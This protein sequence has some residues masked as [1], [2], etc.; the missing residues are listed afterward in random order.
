METSPINIAFIMNGAK[1]PRGGEFLTL[2]LITHLRKDIFHPILIY[3]ED[4][5]IVREIKKSDIE[6]VNFSLNKN[7]TGIYPREIKLYNPIFIFTFI[8]YLLT[9]GS[10]FRLKRILKEHNIHL[11]YCADNLSKLIGGIAGKVAGIKVVAHCHDDFKEYS[12]GVVIKIFYMLLLDKIL[13]VSEKVRKFFVINGRISPKAI[14]VYNGIDTK[15]FDPKNVKDNI[16]EELALDKD[17]VVIGSIG[18]LEKD[19]GQ[20]YLFEAIARLKAEGI[21]NLI[22]LVCGTGP[23]E[24][25]LKKF[26]QESGLKGEIIFLGFR[27]NMPKILKML[28]ILV[29]TS[30]TIESFSM[31][32]VEAMAMKVPVIA[33]NISGLPEVVDDGKTGLLVP[34]GDIDA[35]CNSIKYLI[36]DPGIRLKMGE[37]GR[38]RVLERF[39]IEE[40]VRRTEDIFLYILKGN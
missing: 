26:V 27:N 33:T 19:K 3:A 13:A 30:L 8:W 34:P 12:L 4:G 23:E 28:D 7:I 20:R 9:R 11:I 17:S 35:L 2:H 38:E 24:A 36:Q 5:I 16:R 21:N 14:T 32:A 22:C 10:I 6:S 15:Y 37:N 31:A 40:N 29:I 18:V 39:T 1:P 25:N